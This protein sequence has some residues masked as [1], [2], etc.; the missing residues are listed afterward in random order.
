MNR[1][2]L[3][4]VLAAGVIG[5]LLSSYI[6]H[7]YAKW[8]RLGR[9]EFM[10]HEVLRFDRYMAVPQPML[11]TMAGA[12]LLVFGVA[13]LYELAGLLF[14]AILKSIRSVENQENSNRE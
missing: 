7:D 2:V 13:G 11:R 3:S 4:K 10:A 14:S 5:I 12:T 8:S 6:H 9:Q 1:R